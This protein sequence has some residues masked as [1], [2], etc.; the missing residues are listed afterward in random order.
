MKMTLSRAI[1]ERRFDLTI[2]FIVHLQSLEF[3]EQQL[4]AVFEKPH[5]WEQ[6]FEE[7]LESQWGQ[8]VFVPRL[9]P[10]FR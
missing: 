4:I 7:W 8:T 9:A 2:A 3:T 5:K 6:E 1:D 10:A